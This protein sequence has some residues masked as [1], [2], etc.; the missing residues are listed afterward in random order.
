[1]NQPADKVRTETAFHEAGH[2][3]IGC[4]TGHVPL[5]V[6]I[7]ADGPFVGRTEF[8]DPPPFTQ[9]KQVSDTNTRY[10]E[11][12]VLTELAGAPRSTFTIPDVL[13]MNRIKS[14]MS[15]RVGSLTSWLP[16]KIAISTSPGQCSR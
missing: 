2:A 12:R 4:L 10:I 1:M 16:G 9:L 3:V 6:T 5:S 14:I 11:A 7:I 15:L 8:D 13:M